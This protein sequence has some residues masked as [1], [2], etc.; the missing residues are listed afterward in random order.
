ML[1]VRVPA[2]LKQALREAAE[3]DHGRSLSSM[4]VRVL[5][6][7]LGSQGYLRTNSVD[8]GRASS[9]RHGR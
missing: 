7:W 9:K 4:V 3:D 8:K 6:E 2:D 1:N 5:R